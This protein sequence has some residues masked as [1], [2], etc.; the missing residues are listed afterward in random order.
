MA[1]NLDHA[2]LT[3]RTAAALAAHP[4]TGRFTALAVAWDDPMADVA[5]TVERQVFEA[6][7]GN[8][9]A[10]M[11]AEYG[12]YER[13]SLFFL[14]LDRDTGLPAGAG[15]VIEGGGKTL[16]DAPDLIG[17]DLSAVVEAHGLH[18]GGKIWDFA[19]VG[20]LPDYRGGKSGLAVSSLL[21]RTFL[22][23]GKRAGVKHIVVMLDH[24]A[25]R[26]M[27]LLGAPL[28]AMAG[29][30]PFEYLGSAS[31]RALYVPFAELEP[32]IAEQGRRLR[33]PVGAFEGEIRARGL[34]RLLIRRAAARVS[35]QVATGQGL[36][37]HILL[38]G[39]ER[40]RYRSLKIR[41]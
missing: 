26:N 24:R 25:H 6:A 9:T 32:A 4:A 7:F 17:H 31:T 36:N 40:R 15:R 10:T 30:E 22:Q 14:V 18:D 13:Q 35:E 12:D 5:R 11:T 27:T 3:R 41:R 33:R 2:E 29:S 34:R 16:D 28:V 8:D 20:V 21:Y 38:P 39:L 37:E 23:A 1:Y 19:T